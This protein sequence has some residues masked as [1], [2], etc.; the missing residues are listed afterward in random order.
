VGRPERVLDRDGGLLQTFAADL[1]QLRVDAGTPSYRQLSERVGYSV[2]ALSD[3]AGG[4]RLPGLA[5]TLAYVRGCGGDEAEWEARWRRVRADWTEQRAPGSATTTPPYQGLAWFDRGDAD[6]FFGRARLVEDLVTRVRTGCFV[7]VAGPSGS[8]K[9]S[10]LRAGL[11]PALPERRAVVLTPGEHPGEQ[12]D[13]VRPEHQLV[14]VDQF[15]EVFTLCR[16]REERERFVDGLLALCASGQRAVVIGVRADFLSSCLLVPALASRLSAA[17]VLVGPMDDEELTQAV[18]APATLV[19]LTV[20]RALVTRVLADVRD[21]PGALPLLSHALQETWRLRRSSTLT[22]TDYLSAGGIDGAIARTAEQVYERLDPEQQAVAREILLRLTALGD[23]TEDTKRRVRRAELDLPG[24]GHVLEQLAAARL[25]VLNDDVVDI[26]H[27]AL[28]GAWPRLHGWLADDR[29]ALRVQ[30]QLTQA[31]EG[32]QAIQRDAGALYRGS[33]LALAREWASQVGDRPV[34]TGIERDF[35][36]ASVAAELA[37][38]RAAGR[39]ARQ[40]RALAAA[41]SAALVLVLLGASATVWLWRDAAARAREAASENDARQALS[42]AATDVGQAM[43]LSLSARAQADTVTARGALLSLASR[44]AYASRL[45]LDQE[46]RDVAFNDDATQLVSGGQD[47][48][49]T[50]WDNR[51]HRQVRSLAPGDGAIGAVAVHGNYVASGALDGAV[52]LWELSSG[53]LVARLRDSGQRISGVAFSGDGSTL[54]AIGEAPGVLRWRLPDGTR[55]P[56]LPAS[57]GQRSQVGY[58]PGGLLAV[59]DGESS[60]RVFPSQDSAAFVDYPVPYP[61]TAVAVSPDGTRLAVAGDDPDATLVELGTGQLARLRGHTTYVRSVAF[62]PDGTRVVSGGN[63]NFAIVSDVATGVILTRLTGHTA[64]IYG[65]AV[66]TPAD[67]VAT[68]S[69]DGSVITYNS[70]GPL[71]GHTDNITALVASP[72]GH[73]LA[74]AGRDMTIRVWDAV[75]GAQVETLRGHTARVAALAW[76]GPLLASASDDRTVQLWSGYSFARVR[77]L[78]GHS[79]VVTSLAFAPDGVLA[80][81]SADQTVRLWKPDGTPATSPITVPAEVRQLLFTPDGHLVVATRDGTV[82]V[83][84]RRS[85]DRRAFKVGEQL[86]SLALS[87]DGTQLAVGDNDGGTTLWLLATGGRLA[88]TR[89]HSGTITAVAF[90]PD[91]G[92]LAIGGADQTVT[93]WDPRTHATWAVLT[94]VDP[95]VLA[96]AWSPDGDRLYSAGGDRVISRWL[97]DPGEAERRVCGALAT[98]FPQLPHS[99][100]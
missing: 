61:L 63:D 74:S 98:D 2:T 29:D 68:A 82:T 13:R 30:R 59:V 31:A 32:W 22:L 79:D 37:E 62:S 24:A 23:G 71:V 27:E 49:L 48:R 14:V 99:G 76:D 87:P 80:S 1:R 19:G 66:G 5:L 94:G 96:L 42:L 84:D 38:R 43:S 10:L 92:R 86:T 34:L 88:T 8:G 12:L 33:R 95:D 70:D 60:V 55:L 93:L 7:T 46:V 6:R 75:T 47:G 56:D 18:T 100:C 77:V 90:S 64:E 20:E 17:A 51:T 28:I 58:G 57:G 3:A 11:V 39:R 21:Q 45:Q 25:L 81:G 73:W 72:N 67:H 78:T 15:E 35:L 26:A 65:V 9:S 89:L 36:D 44:P 85:G 40:L 16:D 54:A 69:R 91:G 41:L 83:F 52:L 4:R 97:V 53:R 50:V